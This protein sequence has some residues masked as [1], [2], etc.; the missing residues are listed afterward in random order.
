MSDWISC[1]LTFRYAEQEDPQLQYYWFKI[2]KCLYDAY[3]ARTVIKIQISGDENY[4]YFCEYL[5][6]YSKYGL[7]SDARSLTVRVE[8][9]SS[10]I[11][12]TDL[13]VAADND[14]NVYI[15]TSAIWS[16]YLRYRIEQGE[17]NSYLSAPEQ[18]GYKPFGTLINTG[19]TLIGKNI[20]AKRYRI[21][22]NVWEDNSSQLIF[23]TGNINSIGKGSMPVGAVYV[24]FPFQSEPS[25]LFTGTWQ[26]ITSTY[27]GRFFRAEG[28]KAAPFGTAQEQAIQSHSHTYK[29]N[30]VS[31]AVSSGLISTPQ[32]NLTNANTGST[33]GD[34]TRPTNYA[35]KIWKR[36]S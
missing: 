25:A 13:C 16:S 15:Q 17:S 31:V 3:N 33:G 24:Q 14:G 30:S 34:E 27:A 11:G 5:L 22:D 18:I 20:G 35:I 6:V 28:G 23:D 8:P 9:L 19:W 12:E 4:N 2:G 1:P 32:Y 21:F 29:T 10:R 26:E 7:G 36:I